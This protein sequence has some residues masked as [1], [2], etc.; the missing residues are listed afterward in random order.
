MSNNKT[1]KIIASLALI[2]IIASIVWTWILF[3][4]ESYNS[5]NNNELTKQQL[6][7]LLKSY[8]WSQVATW[9]LTITWSSSK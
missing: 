3:I 9:S 6:E 8:S 4:Y 1:A 5:Q 7:E 2:W